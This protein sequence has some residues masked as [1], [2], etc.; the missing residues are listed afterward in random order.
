MSPLSVGWLTAD[1]WRCAA[2]QLEHLSTVKKYTVSCHF[3]RVTSGVAAPLQEAVR[4]RVLN[5]RVGTRLRRSPATTKRNTPRGK[6]RSHRIWFLRCCR[7]RLMSASTISLVVFICSTGTHKAWARQRPNAPH[8][9]AQPRCNTLTC[10]HQSKQ[11]R[12][13][14]RW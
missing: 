5:D 6:T 10:S 1:D 11:Q 3:S 8:V 12:Y 7:G 4:Q 13:E 14:C 9:K 2:F